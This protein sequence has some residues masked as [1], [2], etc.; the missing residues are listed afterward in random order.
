MSIMLVLCPA[1][2]RNSK[3]LD[4]ISWYDCRGNLSFGTNDPEIVRTI[5]DWSSGQHM[6]EPPKCFQDLEEENE[7][8]ELVGAIQEVVATREASAAFPAEMQEEQEA[9]D[10]QPRPEEQTSAVGVSEAAASSSSSSAVLTLDTLAASTCDF[11]CVRFA[12][13]RSKVAV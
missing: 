3:Q 11:N 5:I 8:R 10:Q 2:I 13:T 9:E 4:G 1:L 12:S 6:Y 7:V